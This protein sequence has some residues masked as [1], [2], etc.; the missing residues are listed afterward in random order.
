VG[1]FRCLA[2]LYTTGPVYRVITEAPATQQIVPSTFAIPSFLFILT[3]SILHH[4]RK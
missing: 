3:F 2:G 4:K 1:L